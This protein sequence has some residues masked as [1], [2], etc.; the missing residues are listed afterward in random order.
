M[1]AGYYWF[2]V[3]RNSACTGSGSLEAD[4][5]RRRADISLAAVD[6]TESASADSPTRSAPDSTASQN[7][8]SG[9]RKQTQSAMMQLYY[10]HVQAFLLFMMFSH[11]SLSTTFCEL[12]CRPCCCTCRFLTPAV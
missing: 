8:S 6:N 10:R 4:H 2:W 9:T 12:S 1:F 3:A 7:T 11:L 5:D